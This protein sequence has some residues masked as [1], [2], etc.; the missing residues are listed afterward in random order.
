[1]GRQVKYCD[2]H[3]QQ[4]RNLFAEWYISHISY[5][6]APSRKKRSWNDSANPHRTRSH[7]QR[8]QT[9]W[10]RQTFSPL[11]AVH[12][13]CTVWFTR[14]GLSWLVTSESPEAKRHQTV[15]LLCSCFVLE[16][17]EEFQVREEFQ[18]QQA[19]EKG[20]RYLGPTSTTHVLLGRRFSVPPFSSFPQDHL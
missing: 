14:I 1:M 10:G 12:L 6:A 7:W 3:L 18:G 11:V 5:R 2:F 9:Q 16:V 19:P 20:L 4:P 8:S 17:G 15:E 13:E